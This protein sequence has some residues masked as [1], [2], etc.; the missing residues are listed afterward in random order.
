M[1][2]HARLTNEFTEDEKCHNLMSWLIYKLSFLICAAR[3]INVLLRLR[4]VLN[5]ETK[6]LIC[7]SFLYS[8]FNYC[9]LVWYFCSKA[10]TDKLEKLQYRALRL[11]VNDF[12]SSYDDLLTK[13]NMPTLHTRR[14]RTIAIEAFQIL[15]KMSPKYLHDLIFFL[16]ITIILSGMKI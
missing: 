3:Q 14:I 8:S 2:A 9:P 11:V 12:T 10:S 7:M 13:A 15:H 16:K 4:N 5:Q 1:A 6:I